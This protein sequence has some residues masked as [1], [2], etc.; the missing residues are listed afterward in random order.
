MAGNP[1][2]FSDARQTGVF[3]TYYQTAC[4]IGRGK[5]RLLD[6]VII[7]GVDTADSSLRVAKISVSVCKARLALLKKTRYIV[8]R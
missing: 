3:D 8:T 2:A 6:R 7:V 1:V 4:R 5:K